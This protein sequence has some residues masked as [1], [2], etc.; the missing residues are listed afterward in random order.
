MFLTYLFINPSASCNHVHEL[1]SMG[2][3]VAYRV[4]AAGVWII[5]SSHLRQST[6]TQYMDNQIE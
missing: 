5:F 4:A 1:L 3:V 6:K 2:L